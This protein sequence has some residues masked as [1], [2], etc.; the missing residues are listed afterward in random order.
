[1]FVFQDVGQLI[2]KVCEMAVVMQKSVKVDDDN[3]MKDQ[4]KITKLQLENEGLRQ[5]LEISTTTQKRIVRD[6][7]DDKDTQTTDS[8]EAQEKDKDAQEKEAQE[9]DKDAQEKEVQDKPKE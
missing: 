5:L 1:M 4:E 6:D 8:L 9:K 3:Y 7:Q 2:D